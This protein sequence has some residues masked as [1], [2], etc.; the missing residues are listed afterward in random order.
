MPEHVDRHAL[1]D[2]CEGHPLVARYYIE[3]LSETES[4]EEAD[5]LLSSG[6]LGTSVEQMYELVWEAID[7]DEDAKHVLSRKFHRPTGNRPLFVA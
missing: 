2:V 1:F 7:P 6:V 3:K 4:E 5:R